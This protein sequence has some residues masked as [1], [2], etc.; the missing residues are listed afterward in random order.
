MRFS[1]PLKQ[2]IASQ[3]SPYMRGRGTTAGFGWN[4]RGIG[5]VDPLRI[6]CGGAGGV[7]TGVQAHEPLLCQSSKNALR[8]THFTTPG[9]GPV[10]LLSR[11]P[12]HLSSRCTRHTAC[13]IRPVGFEGVG[14][15]P[16]SGPSEMATTAPRRVRIAQYRCDSSPWS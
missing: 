8:S 7:D 9:P 6:S 2:N 4:G 10:S 16:Y 13:A 11:M 15:Y 14:W 3:S 1:F 12:A 5:N